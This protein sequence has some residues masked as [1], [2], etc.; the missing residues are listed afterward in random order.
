MSVA[1]NYGGLRP[2]IVPPAAR[3]PQFPNQTRQCELIPC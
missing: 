2:E 1:S 3:R